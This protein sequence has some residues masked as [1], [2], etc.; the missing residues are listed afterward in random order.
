MA[1]LN[2][3]DRVRLPNGKIGVVKGFN[4]PNTVLVWFTEDGADA[5]YYSQPTLQ[6]LPKELNNV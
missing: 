1:T 4:G 3:N 2:V 6:K 5:G